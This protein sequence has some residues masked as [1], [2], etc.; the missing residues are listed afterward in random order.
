MNSGNIPLRYS[1]FPFPG[2]AYLP[3]RDPHPTADRSGHSFGCAPWFAVQAPPSPDRWL[4]CPPYLYGVDLFNFGYW[5]EA[6]ESWEPL[7]RGCVTN[8]VQREFLQGLIQA[9]NALLKRQ[10]GKELAV[11]RLYSECRTHLSVVRS[12]R[13]MGLDVHCWLQAFEDSLSEGNASFPAL[14]LRQ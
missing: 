3:G 12:S 4:A 6:H 11:Y 10:M 2:Y 1:T 7:W 5:W 9:A 8:R 14:I 13:Y